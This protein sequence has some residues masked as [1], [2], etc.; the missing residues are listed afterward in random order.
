M[1]KWTIRLLTG[2]RELAAKLSEFLAQRLDPAYTFE[3]HAGEVVVENARDRNEA[4]RVA[5]WVARN[6]G[7]GLRFVIEGHEDEHGELIYLS[8]CPT[9]VEQ[10]GLT[11]HSQHQ[12]RG[13]AN[14]SL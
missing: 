11:P 12:I 1:D 10:K 4:W 2:K 8:T 13:I 3:A 7:L 5:I 14:A 6:C 9:C